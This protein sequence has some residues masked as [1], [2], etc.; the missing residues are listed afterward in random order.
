[1]LV[2]SIISD[3]NLSLSPIYFYLRHRPFFSEEIS[4]ESTFLA[5]L[6]EFS[7][8]VVLFKREMRYATVIKELPSLVKILGIIYILGLPYL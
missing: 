3:I 8:K 6:F 1:M 2:T 7:K 5:L 4:L